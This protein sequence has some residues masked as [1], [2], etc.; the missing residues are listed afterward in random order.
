MQSFLTAFI[1]EIRYV[2]YTFY[3]NISNNIEIDQ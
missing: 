3:I 1:L 2:L